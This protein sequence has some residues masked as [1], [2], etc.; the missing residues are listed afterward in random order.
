MKLR[1]SIALGA[2]L[3]L[4]PATALCAEGGEGRGSWLTLLF[5]TINFILFVVILAKFGAPV[6]RKFLR[7]RAT[8][9]RETLSRSTSA[10]ERAQ[11]IANQAA[12]RMAQLEAEKKLLAAE[13]GRETEREVARIRELT[14][15]ALGRIR[16]DAELTAGAIADSG[17]RR[18]RTHLAE[19]AAKLARDLIAANFDAADQSRLIE[20]FMTRIRNEARP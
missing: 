4:V 5:F 20:D 8:Q 17:R 15:T 2:I 11:Q 10:F 18:I 16:R 12:V 7:D 19:V 1:H 13:M 9:I 3:L 6:A 14:Q